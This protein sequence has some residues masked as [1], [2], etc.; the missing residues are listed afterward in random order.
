M[1]IYTSLTLYLS[2]VLKYKYAKLAILLLFLGVFA[3]MRKTAISVSTYVRPSVL[4]SA[5]NNSAPTKRIFVKFD[6]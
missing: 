2:D 1:V 5:W 6:I 3:E 4:L